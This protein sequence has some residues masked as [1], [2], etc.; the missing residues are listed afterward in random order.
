MT[1]NDCRFYFPDSS[2]PVSFS[3]HLLAEDTC[4]SSPRYHCARCNKSYKYRVGLYKH[5]KYECGKEPQFQCSH[6]PYK[7]KQRANMKRHTLF[8]HGFNTE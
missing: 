4:D 8:R 3:T 7:S 2:S 5:L 6:C 1:N